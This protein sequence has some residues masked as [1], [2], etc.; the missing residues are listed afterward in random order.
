MAAKARALQATGKQVVSFSMGEPDFPTPASVVE[1]GVRALR[2][3]KTK[4]VATPGILPLREAISEKLKRDNSVLADPENIVV[5]CGAK[6]SLFNALNVLVGE[7]DEV[8]VFAPYWPTY[9]EQVRLAGAHPVIVPC[10]RVSKFVPELD[11]VRASL[12]SRTKA[13]IVNSPNNPTGAVF[14]HK[15]LHGLANIACE[16]D[17]WLIC[18][19]I[20]EKL[21]YGP[22]HLS[23]ASIDPEV[24]ERTV[25]INGCSKAFAMTGWRIGYSASP[26]HVAEKISNFQDQ[27]TSG[28]TSFAQY[29]AVAAMSLPADEVEAMRIEYMARRDLIVS[30]LSAIEG[31]DVAVP[32]GAF[33]VFP[34]FKGHEDDQNLAIKFLERSYVAT[35]PGS[36]FGAN[37][38]IRFSYATSREEIEEGVSRVASFMAMV[39]K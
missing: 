39:E 20:Y 38:H 9:V 33:Y 2:D 15:T 22:S 21:V 18:D 7:G 36:D 23:L 32:D 29:G 3:G 12:T 1:A 30:L 25:T 28:V 16:A 35:V 14:D 34:S 31:V 17:L 6:H 27:V 10:S 24:A 13:V 5:S 37:G 4:Y 8:I 19:E 11:R 26:R